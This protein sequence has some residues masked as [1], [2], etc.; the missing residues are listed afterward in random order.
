LALRVTAAKQKKKKNKKKKEEKQGIKEKDQHKIFFNRVRSGSRKKMWI[1]KS[2][3][4][5]H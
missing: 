3:R 1:N 5:K 4:L 2:F